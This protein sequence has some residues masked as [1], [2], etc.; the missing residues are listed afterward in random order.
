MIDWLNPV[1]SRISE[2]A[3]HQATI[4]DIKRDILDVISGIEINKNEL[5][6]LVIKEYQTTQDINSKRNLQFIIPYINA[7]TIEPPKKIIPVIKPIVKPVDDKID[8]VDEK[9]PNTITSQIEYLEKQYKTNPKLSGVLDNLYKQEKPMYKNTKLSIWFPVDKYEDIEKTLSAWTENQKGIDSN[10][11]ELVIL[12][13]RPNGK[14]SYDQDTISKIKSFK[15]QHPQYN[16]ITYYH[17]FDF[18]GKAKMWEIYKTLWNLIVYR[19][20]KRLGEKDKNIENISQL[21]M[22]LGGADSTQKNPQFVKNLVDEFDHNPQLMRHTS[23]SRL[24]PELVK[25]YPLLEILS[26]LES[27]ISRFYTGGK[28]NSNVGNWTFR[29]YAYTAVWGHNTGADMAEDVDLVSKLN[30][31]IWETAAKNAQT[32]IQKNPTETVKRQEIEKLKKHSLTINAVDNSADRAIWAMTQGGSYTYYA[33]YDKNIKTKDPVKAKNREKRAIENKWKDTSLKYLELTKENLEKNISDYYRRCF[34][35]FGLGSQSYQRYTQK[36]PHASKQE[37]EAKMYE[38]Y[39]R[40]FER[41]LVWAL[42]LNKDMF[43][44]VHGS[45]N[46]DYTQIQWAKVEITEA[47]VQRLIQLHQK[48][49]NNGWYNYW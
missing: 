2:I 42:W 30:R 11:Y 9:L 26:T 19:N 33:R 46:D 21:T 13:N 36:N 6:Q 44:L 23:E 40:P 28:I 17:T 7:L 47:W 20:T 22:R 32:A 5:L 39:D 15:E 43:K 45:L 49:L 12:I 48:K 38:I 3:K 16:I 14:S 41:S 25:S 10:S 8:V 37:K 1:A 4:L 24:D 35:R 29:T 31:Y 34:R 18:D 27:G